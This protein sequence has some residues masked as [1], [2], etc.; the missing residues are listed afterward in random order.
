M[1]KK[2]IPLAILFA[3]I[4]G[5]LSSFC[6][7]KSPVLNILK[8][9]DTITAARSL[10][11][12]DNIFSRSAFT[13]KHHPGGWDYIESKE[14]KNKDPYFS[15]INITLTKFGFNDVALEVRPE[16]T[17]SKDAVIKHYGKKFSMVPMAPENFTVHRISYLPNKKTQLIFGFV[18]SG[19]SEI[20]S[21]ATIRKF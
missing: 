15:V 11:T 8:Q 20:L 21:D 10:K 14:D 19:S 12:L 13:K 9:L 1:I 17:I 3:L 2:V 6:S 7:A 18:Q 4:F 5:S 16:A